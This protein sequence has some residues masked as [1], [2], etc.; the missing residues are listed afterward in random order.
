MRTHNCSS[1][2]VVCFHC[3]CCGCCRHLVV[4]EEL[5]KSLWFKINPRAGEANLKLTEAA[6]VFGSFAS[7]EEQRY[8]RHFPS[9]AS[10][11]YGVCVYV[12]VCVCVCVCACVCVR[13][14]MF[15]WLDTGQP[16]TAGVGWVG[17]EGG[18]EAFFLN[19]DS[20]PLTS[21]PWP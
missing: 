20:N 1:C 7:L 3:S 16:D 21:R 4:E 9:Y 14:R 5:V 8:S 15:E 2:S 13:A 17:W 18:G 10:Y 6:A 11:F 19:Q 12:C